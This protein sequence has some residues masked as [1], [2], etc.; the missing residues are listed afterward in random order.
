MADSVL[1][2]AECKS[3]G[4][5]RDVDEEHHQ[6]GVLGRKAHD[7]RCING[8]KRDHDRNARLIAE[9]AESE[10][11]EVAEAPEA[12]HGA[13]DFAKALGRETLHLRLFDRARRRALLYEKEERHRRNGEDRG[14][15]EH[16]AGYARVKPQAETLAR[17]D[18]K[19]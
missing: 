19:E 18:K 1:H 7:F 2:V 6:N 4:G 14:R 8:R 16:R 3:A 5:G 17:S 15:N 9:A 11:A 10:K 13:C 12:L